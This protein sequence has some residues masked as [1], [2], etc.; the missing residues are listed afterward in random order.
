MKI[1]QVT[2]YETNPTTKKAKQSNIKMGNDSNR[3][4]S[5]KITNNQK[6]MKRYT[7]LIIRTIKS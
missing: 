3:Y 5:K 1:Q 7:S 2:T 4:F 6:Y